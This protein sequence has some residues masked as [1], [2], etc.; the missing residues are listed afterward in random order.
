MK[1]RHFSYL[2][3]IM[4]FSFIL[5]GC[6]GGGAG[7]TSTGADSA[8]ANSTSADSQANGSNTP[9]DGRAER[10][11]ESIEDEYQDGAPM[12]R[13]E[14]DGL[15][16]YDYVPKQEIL[17]AS[18]HS[19][20]VQFGNNVFRNGGYMTLNEFIEQYGDQYDCSNID[21]YVSGHPTVEEGFFF[22]FR[23]SSLE[24]DYGMYL[25]CS[26]PVSGSGPVGDAVICMFKPTDG[27]G[28]G[29]DTEYS[30][31]IYSHGITSEA[32]QDGNI[33]GIED[34]EKLALS[35]GLTASEYYRPT[36]EPKPSNDVAAI[37]E[38]AGTYGI[39]QNVAPTERLLST[40]EL[41]EPNLY[42]AKPILAYSYAHYFDDEGKESY[43][44]N[45]YSIYNGKTV[46]RP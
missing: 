23:I 25:Y 14:V 44:F 32:K 2:A 6:S 17:D 34:I 42:G 29:G 18:L 20:Y 22:S 28:L 11:D 45:A 5:T 36:N 13:V 33:Q 9:D 37:Q 30:P 27:V 46:F 26:E 12:L 24:K 10:I 35:E 1:H 38:H 21:E 41:D 31:C 15:K 7:T 8:A 43:S 39:E 16:I 40:I 3:A 4:A 19:G